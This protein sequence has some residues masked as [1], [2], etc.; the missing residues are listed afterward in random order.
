MDSAFSKMHKLWVSFFKKMFKIW[1]K[2]H[3]QKI[4]EKTFCFSDKCIGIRYI[5]LSLLRTEYLLST[6][7]VLT[8][9]LNPLHVTNSHFFQMNYLEINQRIWKRCCRSDWIIVSAHLPCCLSKSPLKF[10]F[11]DIHL[12]TSLIVRNFGN[13]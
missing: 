3:V 11:L 10:H 1:C 12:T 9:I 5:K 8:N 4:S 13:T 6:V 7:G 2:F